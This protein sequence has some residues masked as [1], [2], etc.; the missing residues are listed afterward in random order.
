MKAKT[1]ETYNLSAED[2][3]IELAGELR[4]YVSSFTRRTTWW[5]MMAIIF[6]YIPAGRVGAVINIAPLFLFLRRLKALN[7]PSQ[8]VPRRPFG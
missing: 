5:K 7:S 3:T 8:T 6:G 4:H 2:T 1:L